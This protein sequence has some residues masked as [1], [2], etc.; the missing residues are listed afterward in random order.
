MLSEPP[1]AGGSARLLVGNGVALVRERDLARRVQ[2]GLERL[3]QLD[4]V[5]DVD[6]YIEPAQVGER[7]EL[8]VREA[9][10]GA[11]ELRLLLPVAEPPVAG[12]INGNGNGMAFD[13][14]CQV[15][16]GVSHFVYLAERARAG[17][18]ASQ[19]E[20]ELQAEV[21]KF[22]VLGS[23]VGKLDKPRAHQLCAQLFGSVRYAHDAGTL[24]GERY[25]VAN[26]AA[27]RFVRGLARD[28]FTDLRKTRSVLRAFY[29]LGQTGKLSA[30]A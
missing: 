28:N 14:I 20:L 7:E 27:H 11:L 2:G 5:V 8:L 21:D 29:Q 6:D 16:E 9:E 25:R 17:R 1:N 22:V 30:A 15:I 10:D 23:S 3:Y 26:D 19:L 24:R 18:E 13:Q 12:A 4:R